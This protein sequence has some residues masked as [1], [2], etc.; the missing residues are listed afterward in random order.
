M[1]RMNEQ[2]TNRQ[3]MG[4]MKHGQNERTNKNKGWTERNERTK[5]R[6]NQQTKNRWNERTKNE[7]NKQTNKQKGW[8]E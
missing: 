7:W 5:D 8:M 3:R 2:T 4:R 6:I 1:D